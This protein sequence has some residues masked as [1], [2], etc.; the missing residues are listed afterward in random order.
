MEITKDDLGKFF[1][2]LDYT[3]DDN[4]DYIQILRCELV[5]IIKC[6]SYELRNKKIPFAEKET[7]TSVWL[8]FRDK[9]YTPNIKEVY[10]TIDE[11]EK[12]F[13]IIINK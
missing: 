3:F 8:K 13:K 7:N 9:Y 12:Q 4:E 10:R 5:K 1:Y 6:E 2:I 11:A